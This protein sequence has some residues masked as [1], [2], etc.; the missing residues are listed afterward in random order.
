MW[1][2]SQLKPER[3]H[4]TVYYLLT[5]VPE[6]NEAEKRAGEICEEIKAKNF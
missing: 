5:G 4:Q 2:K 1:K 6:E 3:Q